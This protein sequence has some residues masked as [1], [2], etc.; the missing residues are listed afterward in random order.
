M[1]KIS[2]VYLLLTPNVEEKERFLTRFQKNY[3]KYEAPL[4][5]LALHGEKTSFH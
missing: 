1:N 3:P 4:E 2:V 5:T